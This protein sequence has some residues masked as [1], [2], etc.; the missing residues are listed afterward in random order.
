[1]KRAR[2][3]DKRLREGDLLLDEFAVFLMNS[4]TV[5]AHMKRMLRRPDQVEVLSRIREMYPAV[6]GLNV[7]PSVEKLPGHLKAL[8]EGQELWRVEWFLQGM[9]VAIRSDKWEKSWNDPKMKMSFKVV[10]MG[11]F[12]DWT[13]M[14]RVWSDSL[15]HPDRLIFKEG[16]GFHEEGGM[17]MQRVSMI[18]HVYDYDHVATAIVIQRF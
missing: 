5:R 7:E 3:L 8:V 4:E 13:V 2:N 6:S 14:L 16:M 9:T 17:R 12:C 15:V 10:E 11:G 18:S 1:M